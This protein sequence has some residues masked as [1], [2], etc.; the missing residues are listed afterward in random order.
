MVT[1]KTRQLLI[2]LQR[3]CFL[4]TTAPWAAVALVCVLP[5]CSKLNIKIIFCFLCN[6]KI[7][8]CGVLKYLKHLD[9]RTPP[10]WHATICNGSNSLGYKNTACTSGCFSCKESVQFAWDYSLL[11]VSY[12]ISLYP[13]DAITVYSKCELL[14]ENS[15]LSLQ[16][17]Y[18]AG[19]EYCSIF[20][21][22]NRSQRL[23]Q[24]M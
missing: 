11:W 2:M 6:R 21:P 24:P 23:L 17:I 5:Y 19:C 10:C 18:N 4:P 16:F 20:M 14:F 12:L 8:V 3:D 13:E 7:L 15:N 9:W 22:P 1:N